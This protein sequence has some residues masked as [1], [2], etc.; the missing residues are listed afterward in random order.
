MNSFIRELKQYRHSIPKQT[1]KSI[2]GQALA[3]DL[4]G[5]RKGL[6]TVLNRKQSSKDRMKN[7]HRST[8]YMLGQYDDI[9]YKGQLA[10]SLKR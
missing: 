2:R 6:E 7:A 9:D 3:G 5:A 8:K 4:V 1:L 10:V